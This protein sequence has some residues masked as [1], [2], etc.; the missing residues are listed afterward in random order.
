MSAVTWGH[1]S[2]THDTKRQTDTDKHT[3]TQNNIVFSLVHFSS[4]TREQEYGNANSGKCRLTN[5][6]LH[7]LVNENKQMRQFLVVP[8]G[9][10][11]LNLCYSVKVFL[12][13]GITGWRGKNLFLC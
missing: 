3:H 4:L 11:K 1:F 13:H 12:M 9:Y 7:V 8:N 5:I 10:N 6:T 2:H